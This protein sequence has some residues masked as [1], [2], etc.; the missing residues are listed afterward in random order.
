MGFQRSTSQR[1]TKSDG[2]CGTRG[3]IDQMNQSWQKHPAFA[4]NEHDELRT[5][6]CMIMKDKHRKGEFQWSEEEDFS[7][8]INKMKL[9][10]TFIDHYVL[11]T[12]A[13]TNDQDVI[14]VPVN[15]SGESIPNENV[16][17][18]P[19]RKPI[20]NIDQHGRKFPLILALFE[21]SKFTAGHY[22]SITPTGDSNLLKFLREKKAFDICHQMGWNNETDENRKSRKELMES[23]RKQMKKAENDTN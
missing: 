9:D 11:Q 15:P 6:T 5:Y 10:G 19:G 2:N 13:L 12:I 16:R 4:E 23:K 14:I 20:N 22:Q 18:L 3:L 17:I 21:E 7:I 8:Y 1:K